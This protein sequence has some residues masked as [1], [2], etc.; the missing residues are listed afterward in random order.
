MLYEKVGTRFNSWELLLLMAAEDISLSENQYQT[1]EERYAYLKEIMDASD[2]PLLQGA[3]I[4]VQGSIG[5]RTTVLPSKEAEGFMKTIDADAVVL[6]PHAGKASALEV[7]NS[8]KNRF[9][10][11]SRVSAPI[12]ELRRGVRIVYAD[13]NPGFHIDITPA[14]CAAGNTECDGSGNLEVPDRYIGWKCSSPKDYSDWL[15]QVCLK[16]I[17][18][19]MAAMD[20]IS[21]REAAS[22]D[23][24]PEFRDY[25]SSSP[26]QAAIKLLKR[27][28]D[29]W[30]IQ[31]GNEDYRPISAIITTLAAQAYNLLAENENDNAG[32]YLN[33]ILGIID[34]MP[35]FIGQHS[36][37]Y[38]VLNPCDKNENFA[39]KWNRPKEGVEYKKA[40]YDWHQSA[41]AD[42]RL[43]LAE[44][45][46]NSAFKL[47][48]MA[49]FGIRNSVYD[50]FLQKMPKNWTLPGRAANVTG[51]TLALGLLTGIV[52]EDDNQGQEGITPPERLG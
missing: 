29:E 15:D 27:H 10:D 38:Y 16:R 52:N 19:S 41:N 31:T 34:L 9:T 48:L 39:E 33:I 36:G 51:N 25:K 28:R 23:S 2:D 22:Q 17:Q 3:H 40:F 49:K 30:A 32:P 11:G 46:S 24:L 12:Q 50:S 35:D 42:F 6:L 44:F 7:L 14:R 18:F 37:Y 45:D 4:F 26:L 21:I 8:I 20:S 5:L 13:E 1:I 43:G 47:E